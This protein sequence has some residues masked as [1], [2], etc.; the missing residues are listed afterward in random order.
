M[1]QKKIE[2]W[3]RKPSLQRE[4][5]KNGK[6][7]KLHVNKA[8]HISNNTDVS[9]WIIGMCTTMGG[10]AEKI[11]RTASRQFR[12]LAS[13]NAVQDC[14]T[15]S[16]QSFL[17]EKNLSLKCTPADKCFIDWICLFEFFFSLFLS[18]SC[19]TQ[20]LCDLLP[21]FHN[22]FAAISLSFHIILSVHHSFI[23]FRV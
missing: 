5:L 22:F 4:G 21:I 20:F 12:L 1:S 18:Y 8:S 19:L 2:N 11:G 10:N 23:K 6:T 3:N 13:A 16:F 14:R 9:S 7:K 17:A 15:R